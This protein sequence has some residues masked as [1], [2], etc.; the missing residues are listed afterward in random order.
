MTDPVLIVL[1]AV[2]VR[3]LA[4]LAAARAHTELVRIAAA[5]PG[6]EVTVSD[7][8][9]DTMRIRTRRGARS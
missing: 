5:A 8:W 2:G 4:R 7:R 9:G 6:T 3:D 1:A